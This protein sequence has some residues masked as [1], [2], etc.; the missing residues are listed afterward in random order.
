MELAS[1]ISVI[2][3]YP[4]IIKQEYHGNPANF[5]SRGKV[6]FKLLVCLSIS[7]K[8]THELNNSYVL[9]RDSSCEI[10]ILSNILSREHCTLVL[11]PKAKRDKHPYYIIRDGV[12]SGSPSRNGTWVNGV[13]INEITR[14]NHQDIITFGRD[15]PRAIFWESE[16]ENEKYNNETFPA[17][18]EY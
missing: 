10:R 17:D 12:F 5:C 18:Y 14:L 2:S 3:L 9:G 8:Q 15:Y 4:F 13:R 16:L 7:D 11:M 1:N 6:N